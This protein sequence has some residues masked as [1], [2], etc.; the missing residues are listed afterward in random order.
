MAAD[1]TDI[2]LYTTDGVLQYSPANPVTA[3][4][5]K[6]AHIDARDL[7]SSEI[8]QFCSAADGQALL[9]EAF[10]IVGLVNPQLFGV[11]VADTLGLGAALPIV[12]HVPCFN[13]VDDPRGVHVTCRVRAYAAE[14]GSDRYAVELL[15]SNTFTPYP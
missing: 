8:E 15:G 1:P 2:A 9:D 11:E 10:A 3:A 14:Y 5:I 4:A 6:A 7:S 13:I 12:P